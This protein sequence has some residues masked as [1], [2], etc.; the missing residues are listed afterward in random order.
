MKSDNL[1]E[2]PQPKT[3]TSEPLPSELGSINQIRQYFSEAI[4]I[5]RENFFGLVATTA[6]AMITVGLISVTL[7][8]LGLVGG[9]L[10]GILV[11]V[12]AGAA[13]GVLFGNLLEAFDVVVQPAVNSMVD[14]ELT[15]EIGEIEESAEPKPTPSDYI[16]VPD[17]ISLVLNSDK[18]G[19]YATAGILI[20]LI[21]SIIP[22]LGSMLP[23]VGGL[24]WLLLSV[25]VSAATI[26]VLP[27]VSV[28]AREPVA[29][30]SENYELFMENPG[31]FILM[32]LSLTLITMVGLF[33][34]VV[35]IFLTTPIAVLLLLIGY[36]KLGL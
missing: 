2:R 15:D 23:L 29:A 24:V 30:L 12:I 13:F 6:I 25:A 11:S 36:R 16:S 26:F 34:F 17:Y 19:R 31:Y 18:T 32:S 27:M 4:K 35:G 3:E 22:S 1:D 33:G 21:T 7:A 20:S 28:G 8:S 14:A 10:S 9:F 5:Y